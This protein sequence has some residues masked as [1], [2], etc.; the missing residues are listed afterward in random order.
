MLEEHHELIIELMAEKINDLQKKYGYE[1]TMTDFY[2]R[3]CEKL[4]NKIQ[5]LKPK[6]GR[7]VKKRGRGRPKG[8]R[9]V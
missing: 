6:R 2:R 5:E 8:S 9:N 3:Y 7:P 4:E 1:L